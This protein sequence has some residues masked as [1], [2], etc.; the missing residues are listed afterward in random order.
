MRTTKVVALTMAGALLAACGGEAEPAP[1]RV[2]AAQQCDG[3]LSARAVDALERVL[4]TEEFDAAPVGGLDRS[5]DQLA[6]DYAQGLRRSMHSPMCRP[7]PARASAQLDVYFGLYGED[8]L[9]GDAHPV[10]LHPYDMGREAQSGTDRAYLFV[11]C[12]SPRLKGSEKRPARIRGMLR[13]PKSALPDTVATRE[14][15][16]TVLHSVTLAVVKRLGCSGDAGLDDVPVLK[17]K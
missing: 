2:T 13:F 8:D 10:G 15:N 7:S 6:E 5:A 3:A 4:G 16:L 11:E 9:F 1:P 14:A 17:A 12:A